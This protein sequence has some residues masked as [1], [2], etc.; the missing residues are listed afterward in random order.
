MLS[1]ALTHI[2]FLLAGKDRSPGEGSLMI[3]RETRASK[4]V[5]KQ[6]GAGVGGGWPRQIF[7]S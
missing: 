5:E 6:A 4:E 1:V 3:D 2:G 7:R